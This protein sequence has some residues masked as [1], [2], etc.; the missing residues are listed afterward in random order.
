MR[1][2]RT[3][4]IA[5][6]G[7]I[8]KFRST[9]GSFGPRR[10]SPTRWPVHTTFNMGRPTG[11]S[12]MSEPGTGSRHLTR[13]VRP[14]AARR[15]DAAVARMRLRWSR[16]IGL[17]LA[18]SDDERIIL[19][20]SDRRIARR[21]F[22]SGGCC[23]F[24]LRAG[25]PPGSADPGGDSV[26]FG[27]RDPERLRAC[28]AA[29]ADTGWFQPGEDPSNSFRGKRPRSSRAVCLQEPSKDDSCW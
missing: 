2:E 26:A 13:T 19:R 10:P 15:A 25:E 21:I 17:P 23:F 27:R 1:R 12:R 20:S 14:Q 4:L 18:S 22:G 28:G 16:R 6:A 3:T 7:T 8:A 11:R 9:F 29:G 5:G 24:G